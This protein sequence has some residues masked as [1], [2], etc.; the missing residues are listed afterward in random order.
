MN[1]A[2]DE[3]ALR[4]YYNQ[5]YMVPAQAYARGSA[6]NAPMILRV[7]RERFPKK[8]KLLEVGCSYGFLLDA[9]RRDGWAT[10]GVELDDGAAAYGRQEL[11]LKIL[12]GTLKD[13]FAQ[14]DLPYDAIA[15]FHVIEHLRDP[16]GFLGLCR[17]LL[18]EGGVLVLKTPNVA[19]WIA[20]RTGSSWQWL[21]PPAHIHLFSSRALEL[22]LAKSGFQVEKIWSR[23]G[24]AHNNLFELVCAAGRYLGKK[25][26]QNTNGGDLRKS[27]ADDWKVNAAR[28]AAEA[29]YYPIGVV[30]D[31]WLEKR[32]L[33]PELV[34]IA[35]A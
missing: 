16:V 9:A 26:G 31:P 17:E 3:E 2:P 29:V 19:S 6:R 10:T 28:A 33:Q 5:S 1:P 18:T 27:W 15:T 4:A 7:L 24:D 12:S 25:K 20:K 11:G 32:G 34:A 35:R 8:G 13:Q 30:V 14:L 22:A 23:R 21:S